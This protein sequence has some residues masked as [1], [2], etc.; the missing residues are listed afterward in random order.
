VGK[1]EDNLRSGESSG[2]LEER[3][4]LRTRESCNTVTIHRMA[5]LFR[6]SLAEI[7]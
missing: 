7:R 1:A 6:N 2:Q 5:A 3:G 4:K